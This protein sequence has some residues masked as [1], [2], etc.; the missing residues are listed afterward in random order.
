MSQKNNTIDNKEMKITELSL[1][2]VKLVEGKRYDDERGFFTELF[3]AEELMKEG[4]PAFIQDNLSC[5]KRGVF[6]GMHLQKAPYAQAKLVR[7]V[8]GRVIDFALDVNP[9]SDTFGEAVGVELVADDCRALYIPG[10]YAHGF[11][12]LEDDSRVLYKVDAPYMPSHE[13]AYHFSH[14]TILAMAQKFIQP[15]QL[16]ISDKDLIAPQLI[17][18]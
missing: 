17:D 9:A 13:Q 1:P 11:V 3:K 7:A 12:A 4:F 5:S 16:I 15:D 10:N 2:G 6:R 14:P 18:G 8:S